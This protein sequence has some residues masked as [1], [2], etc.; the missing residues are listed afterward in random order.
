MSEA[1]VQETARFRRGHVVLGTVLGLIV[2]GLGG[3]FSPHQ[4]PSA[5]IVVSTPAP[6]PTS[7]PT[8]TPAPIRVHVSGAV[9]Q[10]AVYE[11]APCSIVQ[12]A[13]NAAGGPASDA[14]LDCINLA[15]E[16][17]DQ[18]Q[19]YVPRQGEKAPPPPVSGGESGGEG[20]G[21]ALVNINTATA[22]ELETLPRIGPA[23]AQR[24]L[25]YR[26]ANGPFEAVEDIQDV[27][28]I[29]PATF[30]GLKDLITVGR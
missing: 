14:D 12:D 11:L 19:V 29:G 16:L 26:E 9:Q 20:T 24:I 4:Q 3:Y 27:P 15:L 6:T 25:E 8:P 5:P 10:P 17:Q 13:V 21:G 18:Q 30:E 1:A 22:A 23:T 2:G 28:G 7:I